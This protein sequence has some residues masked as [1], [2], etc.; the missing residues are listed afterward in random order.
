MSDWSAPTILTFLEAYQNEPCL[1]NSKDADHKN[2]QKVNDAWNAEAPGLP[3]SIA[4]ISVPSNHA[5]LQCWIPLLLPSK[6]L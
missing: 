2:R 4:Y 3:V 6:Y 1:W 5:I